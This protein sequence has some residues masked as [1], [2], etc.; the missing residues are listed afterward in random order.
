MHRV[1]DNRWGGAAAAAAAVAMTVCVQVV[2]ACRQ[3]A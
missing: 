2:L 1:A 3:R